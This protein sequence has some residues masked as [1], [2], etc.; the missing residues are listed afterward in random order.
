VEGGRWKDGERAAASE[1]GNESVSTHEALIGRERVRLDPLAM[2]SE[3]QS[4]TI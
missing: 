4:D 1:H 2:S 3:Q